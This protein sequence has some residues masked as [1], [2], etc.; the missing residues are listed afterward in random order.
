MVSII[1]TDCNNKAANLTIPLKD[2]VI[3]LAS[4][5]SIAYT[6]KWYYSFYYF[7]KANFKKSKN[8]FCFLSVLTFK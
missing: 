8:V 4:I 6:H 1:R 3:Y 5:K 7:R 2:G